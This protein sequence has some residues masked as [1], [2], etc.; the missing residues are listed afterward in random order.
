MDKN[1]NIFTLLKTIILSSSLF[2]F[3]LFFLTTTQEFFT[4]NKLYLLTATALILL[5]ISLI[6]FIVTKKVLIRKSLL[7]PYIFIFAVSIALSILFSS[8]NKVQALLNANFGLIAIF[9]L[10][11]MFYY[12]RSSQAVV[13]KILSASSI[14]V[15]L[16]TLVWFFNPLA[17]INLPSQFTFLKNASFTTLGNQIDLIV[18]LGFILIAVALQISLDQK[19]KISHLAIFSVNVLAFIASIYSFLK[20]PDLSFPPFNLSW[21]AAIEILKNPLSAFFGAGIDNFAAIFTKV[22]D[23]NYNQSSL[24]Q[25]NAFN[26][27]RSTILHF[28]AEAGFFGFCAFGLLIVNLLKEAAKINRLILFFI[29]LVIV[30]L[31]LLPPSLTLLFLFFIVLSIVDDS[32][33]NDNHKDHN[34]KSHW[35]E[36]AFAK[37]EGGVVLVAILAVISIGTLSYFFGRSYAAEY[38]FKMALNGL[39]KNQVKVLYD[40]QRRAIILNPYIERFRLN[41]SQ[42]NLLI[43]SNLAAKNSDVKKGLSEQDRTMITQAIQAAIAEAKAVTTLNPQKAYNWE[44]LASIYINLLNVAQGADSWTIS[45]YQRAIVLDPQNSIY[46]L[47]LGGV[48]YSLA[49][50]SEAS[51]FFE[52]AS[53]LK[54]DWPNAYYNLAWSYFQNKDYQKAVDSMRRSISL[55]NPVKDAKDLEKAQKDLAEFQSKIPSPAVG[56]TQTQTTQEEQSQFKLNLPTPGTATLEPKLLLPTESS[57]EAK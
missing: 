53:L 30:G 33:I 26:I 1:N 39:Q 6:E 20:N 5:L 11:V 15:S 31:I 2:L 28:F 49:N 54:P 36:F 4:T 45:S 3:P 44:N 14:V 32:S 48:Y 21:Y 37:R 57:P 38:V 24:W 56:E 7:D 23:V 52:Q 18:F 51:K 40:N 19:P 27:S 8:P 41:F 13:M 22:K 17:K 12:L 34:H 47:N 35:I 9:S 55:L 46:R 10:S 25:I 50:Y 43:A 29:I 16:L 42:T